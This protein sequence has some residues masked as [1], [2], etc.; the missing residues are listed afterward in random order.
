MVIC[1]NEY[2]K[3]ITSREVWAV[4]R[5]RHTDLKVFGSYSAPDGDEFDPEQCRMMTEYGF[6]GCDFPIIGSETTWDKNHDKPHERLNEKH[7][8]WLCVAIDCDS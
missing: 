7:V 2:K 4:I 5:A 8:F 6:D 3:I 1:M